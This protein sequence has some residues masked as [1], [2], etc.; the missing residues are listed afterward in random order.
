MHYTCT[1]IFTIFLV[2]NVVLQE[3]STNM[4]EYMNFTS[5]FHGTAINHVLV[6]STHFTFYK[7]FLL[8]HTAYMFWYS[9]TIHCAGLIVLSVLSH[10]LISNTH[11]LCNLLTQNISLVDILLTSFDLTADDSLPHSKASC[12]ATQEIN[13]TLTIER[14]L[15]EHL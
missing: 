4:P 15:G 13:C 7:V 3:N 14:R 11:N 8:V 10:K 12:A 1:F 9:V 2:G 5:S 6:S